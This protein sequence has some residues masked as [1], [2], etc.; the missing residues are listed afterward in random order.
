MKRLNEK[1]GTIGK[2]LIIVVIILAI[3]TCLAFLITKN[4]SDSISEEIKGSIKNAM[5][6]AGFDENNIVNIL[7][8][9]DDNYGHKIYSVSCNNDLFF[10]YTYDNGQ[11]T[12]IK[13]SKHNIIYEN[14]DASPIN[15][16]EKDSEKIY[17]M[18]N[19]LGDYGKEDKFGS[20]T[21]IRYYIPEGSYTAKALTNNAQFFIEKIDIHKNEYGYDESEAVRQ[22]KLGKIDSEEKIEINSDECILL[23]IG[24]SISLEK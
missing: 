14:N 13:D 24:S 5:K 8:K 21:F 15:E 1:G 19:Q 4:E 7:P 2:L 9:S 23:V 11:V 18:Y 6:E 20:E 16:D 22:V 3:M 17:L 10:V 12:A